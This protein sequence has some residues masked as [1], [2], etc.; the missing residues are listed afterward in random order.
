MLDNLFRITKFIPKIIVETVYDIDFNKLY[1]QGK[2]YILFDLD[3]TLLPYDILYAYDEL[4]DLLNN[5]RNIGFKIMIVSNN[6]SDRVTKFC[7]DVDMICITRAKKP[8]KSGFKK[9]MRLL[10]C[11]D[12]QQVISVGDQIMT[13]ILGSNRTKIDSILVRPLKKSNEKWYT[14]ANRKMEKHVLQRIKKYNESIYK[15]IEEKHEY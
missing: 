1:E 4:R 7:N 9:G 8:F 14:K 5:I 15:E 12:K 6:S 2:R 10:G 3:N 11:T 13:D